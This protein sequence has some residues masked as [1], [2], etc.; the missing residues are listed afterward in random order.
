MTLVDLLLLLAA[1]A[2]AWLVWD[3]MRTREAANTAIRAACRARELLFLDDTV[4]LRSISV[5]RN[6]AGH[7]V[8]QRVFSFDYSDTGDNRRRATVTMVGDIVAGITIP[9]APVGETLH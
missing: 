8:L 4:A 7:L 5:T 3:S 9:P 1:G 6:D 2:L